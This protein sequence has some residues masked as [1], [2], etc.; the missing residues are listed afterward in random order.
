MLEVDVTLN[1]GGHAIA[2]AFAMFDGLTALTGVSG[3]GKTSVLDMIAGLVRPDRGRIAVGGQLVT[4]TLAR[5]HLPPSQ[6]RIGYVFQDARLFPHLPV[7]GN[8]HY[9]RKAL[10]LAPDA[11]EEARIIRMLGLD[12]L[13]DRRP[14]S[15]SGGEKQRVAIGRALVGQP[16]LLLLDEPLASVDSSRKSEILQYIERVRD[17]L[18]IPVLYVTHSEREV[19][20]L[21]R[22]VV[23]IEAR[24]EEGR[25]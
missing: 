2:A 18:R 5:L 17:E 25:T 23:H 12:L 6:R 21:A 13:L 19:A 14:G 7:R 15:L 9:G 8:L 22:H 24:F 10:G 3:A 1:R 11:V 20:R 16:R 4:D